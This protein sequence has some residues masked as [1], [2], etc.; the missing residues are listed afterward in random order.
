MVEKIG[1]VSGSLADTANETLMPDLLF[2]DEDLSVLDKQARFLEG[3]GISHALGL[4]AEVIPGASFYYTDFAGMH[5]GGPR[6]GFVLLGREFE[7]RSSKVMRKPGRDKFGWEYSNVRMEG[8]ETAYV[9]IVVTPD[10]KSGSLELS[11]FESTTN[12][13]LDGEDNRENSWRG[14]KYS[15]ST[16][17][18][19]KD[20]EEMIKTLFTVIEEANLVPS[21]DRQKVI[22]ALSERSPV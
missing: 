2:V 1:K 15:E 5:P 10:T 21:D 3:S 20:P 12:F 14:T 16:Y 17:L 19:P 22:Q 8:T 4:A 13:V 18:A 11:S 6:P 7:R 9:G